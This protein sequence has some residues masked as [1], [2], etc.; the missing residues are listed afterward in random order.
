MKIANDTPREI[1]DLLHVL[2]FER[3]PVNQQDNLLDQLENVI[4]KYRPFIPL[5][6][7]GS[8]QAV[9]VNIPG[10]PER[11]VQI[12]NKNH[13]ARIKPFHKLLAIPFIKKWFYA[14]LPTKRG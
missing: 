13:W 3:I 6:Q 1:L 9:D 7:N 5:R 12:A 14:N 8:Y 11:L 10:C 2:D 4:E